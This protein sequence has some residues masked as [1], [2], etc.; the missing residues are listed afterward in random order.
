MQV[1]GKYIFPKS[2]IFVGLL[3]KWYATCLT[4]RV[5]DCDVHM[6]LG[7]NLQIG[8]LFKNVFVLIAGAICGYFFAACSTVFS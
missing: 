3:V 1:C 2:L 5:A 4:F 8:I 6:A 7:S